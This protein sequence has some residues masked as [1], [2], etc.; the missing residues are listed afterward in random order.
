VKSYWRLEETSVTIYQSKRSNIP[1]DSNPQIFRRKIV[2]TAT[3]HH[4]SN[5]LE[6]GI[7]GW[8]ERHTCLVIRWPATAQYAEPE[9]HCYHLEKSCVRQDRNST[10]FVVTKWN[11]SLFVRFNSVSQHVTDSFTTLIKRDQIS[12]LQVD[13]P[14]LNSKN[15][16]R[17]LFSKHLNGLRRHP[18]SDR[19]G[20]DKFFPGV[21]VTGREA[22]HSLPGTRYGKRGYYRKALTELRAVALPCLSRFLTIQK[23]LSLDC[24]PAYFMSGTWLRQV[25]L[26]KYVTSLERTYHIAPFSCVLASSWRQHGWR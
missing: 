16:L 24:F 7:S 3:L 8:C 21:K 18:D 20:T 2:Y 4:R 13:R 19:M 22:D 15:G 12:P 6:T 11:Q 23:Y 17:F 14:E 9:K 26:K 5:R 1:E 10:K 25:L